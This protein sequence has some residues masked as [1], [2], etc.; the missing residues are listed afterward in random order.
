MI[1]QYCDQRERARWRKEG[2]GHILNPSEDG[3]IRISSHLST[4]QDEVRTDGR[5]VKQHPVG[6]AD[7]DLRVLS[8][9]IVITIKIV[10]LKKIVCDL[11]LGDK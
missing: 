7:M 6:G 3:H 9:I 10:I 8:R 1:Q 2:G 4:E 11:F 5:V